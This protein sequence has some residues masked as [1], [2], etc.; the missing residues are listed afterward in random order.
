[1]SSSGIKQPPHLPHRHLHQGSESRCQYSIRDSSQR[2][3]ILLHSSE[4]RVMIQSSTTLGESANSSAL[5]NF[6][7][8]DEFVQTYCQH[9][10]WNSRHQHKNSAGFSNQPL[11][12]HSYFTS[13]ISDFKYIFH[14]TLKRV[15]ESFSV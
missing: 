11:P 10:R 12:G 3:Q 1:M 9:C 2:S 6:K 13:N 15:L 7:S 5:C 14:Q 4:T 8:V